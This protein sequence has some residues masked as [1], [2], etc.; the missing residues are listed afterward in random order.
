MG[1]LILVVDDDAD[2]RQVV[3][4]ILESEGYAVAL[5]ANGRD[6]LARLA[7]QPPDAILLDLNMPVMSGWE[8]HER[9]K[10]QKS[11]IP[12]VFM[13]AGQEAQ[14]EARAHGATGYLAKPFEMDDLLQTVEQLLAS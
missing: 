9:L 12:V 5:A 13:T 3:R 10:S 6:A 7:Q 11:R 8:F 2:I 14:R 1:G 4:A